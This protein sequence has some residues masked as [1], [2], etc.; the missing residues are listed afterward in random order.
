MVAAR[1]PQIAE[2]ELR[3]KSQIEPGKNKHRGEPAPSIS[4]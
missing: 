1:H 2:H 3:E 4:G